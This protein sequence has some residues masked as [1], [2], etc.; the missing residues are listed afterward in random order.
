MWTLGIITYSGLSAIYGGRSGI[1]LQVVLCERI[2]R[3]TRVT[4]RNRSWQAQ[5]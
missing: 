4:T 5:T 1:G 2:S 3:N